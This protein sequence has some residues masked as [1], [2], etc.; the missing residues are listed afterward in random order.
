MVEAVYNILHS[1]HPVRNQDNEV[2]S[3]YSLHNKNQEQMERK[4]HLKSYNR[5]LLNLS[6]Q[7]YYANHPISSQFETISKTRFALEGGSM[8]RG[9]CPAMSF[10]FVC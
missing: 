9:D 6:N 2:T 8:Y 7:K 3:G 1:R 10:V 4:D 5:P